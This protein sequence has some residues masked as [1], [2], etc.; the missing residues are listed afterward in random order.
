MDNVSTLLAT[1]DKIIPNRPAIIFMYLE[2]TFRLLSMNVS[3]HW[4]YI[5][6]FDD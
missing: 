3:K 1:I 2:Y 6:I 5:R 4:G